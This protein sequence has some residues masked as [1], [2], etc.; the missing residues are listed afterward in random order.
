MKADV[1]SVNIK[2][3]ANADWTLT[4]RGDV[5]LSNATGSAGSEVSGSA[6][7]T[8][9]ASFPANES[10]DAEKVYTLILACSAASVNETITITQA[11]A[12]AAGEGTLVYTLNGN[13]TGGSNGYAT[14]SD[15]TQGDIAWKAMGNTTMAPWRFG[16]KNLTNENR[17]IY[18]TTAIS[19]NISRVEVTSGTATATVNSLTISVHNSAADAGSGSNA[20]ATKTV[21]SGITSATVV[22]SKEDATSWANKFYRIVYNVSAGSSNQ[23]VQFVKAEFYGE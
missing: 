10:T 19:N 15:I 5:T 13:E 16:G 7:A 22:L 23:Y 17:A 4:A 14:D 8:V 9:T 11:K 1:T 18:S 21:T 3:L 20:I 2:I 12:G 6:D